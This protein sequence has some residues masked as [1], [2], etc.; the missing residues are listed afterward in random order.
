MSNNSELTE[1]KKVVTLNA[2]Q[3]KVWDAVATAE[4]ITAWWMLNDFEPVEG[5]AFTLHAGEF[6]DSPCKVT[7]IKPKTIVSFDWGTMYFMPSLTNIVVK[8]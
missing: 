6:G 1:I 7:K 8:F 3:D 4:G 2:N 5:K